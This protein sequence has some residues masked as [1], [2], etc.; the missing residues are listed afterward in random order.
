[1][2]GALPAVV[3]YGAQATAPAAAVDAPAPN[4]APA[5]VPLGVAAARFTPKCVPL[6]VPRL[7]IDVPPPRGVDVRLPPARGVELERGVAKLERGVTP[8][9][10]RGVIETVPSNPNVSAET[11]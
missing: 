4:M 10:A 8:E 9:G 3:A 6:V 7:V 5:A 11:E 1:M 2:G